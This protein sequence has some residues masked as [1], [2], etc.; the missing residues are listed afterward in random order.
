[1]ETSNFRLKMVLKFIKVENHCFRRIQN[2]ENYIV[3]LSHHQFLS[4]PGDDPKAYIKKWKYNYRKVTTTRSTEGMGESD[5]AT[6]IF[7]E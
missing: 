1:M 4:V 3:G 7:S 2:S 5:D 6:S